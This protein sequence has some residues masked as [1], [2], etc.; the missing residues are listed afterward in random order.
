MFYLVKAPWIVQQ[1]YW[2]C[3]WKVK[4][5]EKKIYLTFDDGPTPSVTEFVLEQLNLFEAKATFFCI[6]KNVEDHPQLYQQIIQA[7]H[8]IGN[9]TYSHLNGWK[10]PDDIYLKD[11]AHAEQLIHSK[12]FRPPYGRIRKFQL[13]NLINGKNYLFKPVMWHILSGDFDTKTT[14]EQCYL[15]VVN[16]A[17][18]GSIVVFHDS[19]KAFPNMSSSLPKVLTYLTEKG[20]SFEKLEEFVLK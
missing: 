20:F 3:L 19:E 13:Y 6:G 8:A 7:G 11:I 5:D 10:T 2:E 4:T 1:Y 18:N 16:N 12:L 15:N 17:R 9:H 14:P